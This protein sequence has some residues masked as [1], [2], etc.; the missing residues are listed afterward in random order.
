M[1]VNYRYL[2]TKFSGKIFRP[3]RDEVSEHFRILHN[4][5]LCDLYRSPSIARV[6]KSMKIQQIRHGAD[7]EHIQNFGGGN[8]LKC[9]YLEVQE[10]KRK[11]TLRW[12]LRRVDV[13]MGGG[14]NWLMLNS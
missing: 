1:N 5:K 9:G 10:V 12:I 4:K 8:L 2:K 7:K 6:V 13:R 14:W 3:K 11:I